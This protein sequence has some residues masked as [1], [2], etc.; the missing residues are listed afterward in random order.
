MWL[1]AGDKTSEEQKIY[2]GVITIGPVPQ[3]SIHGTETEQKWG[4]LVPACLS[5]RKSFVASHGSRSK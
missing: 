4:S 5:Y 3:N 1:K 2:S